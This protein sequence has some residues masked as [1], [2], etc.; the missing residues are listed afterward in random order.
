MYNRL[1]VSLEFTKQC[2]CCRFYERSAM[3]FWPRSH[4]WL[5]HCKEGLQ[6]CLDT[7][8]QLIAKAVNKPELP[9]NAQPP[10]S[11][12]PSAA[13]CGAQLHTSGHLESAHAHEPT[14]GDQNARDLAEVMW[15]TLGQEMLRKQHLSIFTQNTLGQDMPRKSS[16]LSIFMQSVGRLDAPSLA[17]QIV[18]RMC[19]RVKN[20]CCSKPFSL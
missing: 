12:L 9:A 11:I 4:R 3:M 8:Q 6:H 18:D 17:V 15:T 13:T 7:L 10:A 14:A 16:D 20:F 19:D 5:I 2:A 1:A